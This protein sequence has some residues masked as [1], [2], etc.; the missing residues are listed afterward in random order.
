[1]QKTFDLGSS[2]EVLGWG[3]G[4]RQARIADVVEADGRC[5]VRYVDGDTEWLLLASRPTKRRKLITSR[6][7]QSS[8][9]WRWTAATTAPRRRES[10]ESSSAPPPHPARPSITPS[11]TPPTQPQR[12]RS[13]DRDR[14]ESESR[15]LTLS[16]PEPASSSQVTP[17]SSAESLTK[18]TSRWTGVCWSNQQRKWK[19]EVQRGGRQAYL[20]IFD[21]EIDAA[22]KVWRST[23]V[24]TTKQRSNGVSWT[25]R[26]MKWESR[27]LIGVVDAHHRRDAPSSWCS[28]TLNSSAVALSSRGSAFP[29]P[30]VRSVHPIEAL[31]ATRS[32]LWQLTRRSRN[33]G[34]NDARSFHG[35]SYA[36]EGLSDRHYWRF[37]FVIKILNQSKKSNMRN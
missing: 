19:A 7:G 18:K 32:P 5:R 3:D 24:T 6:A 25:V 11:I 1:M 28:R 33:G 4:W 9:P 21:D 15:A 10:A 14:P 30:R 23:A 37:Y 22:N 36:P 26:G 34:A 29:A 12:T 13:D 27:V 31:C 16:E 8:V 2:L 20:G 35:S 17:S